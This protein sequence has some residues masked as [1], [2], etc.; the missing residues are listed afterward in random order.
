ME[1]PPRDPRQPLLTG[2]LILRILLVSALLVGGAW[3]LFEWER[4]NGATLAE[5]RTAAL[6]LFVTVEAFYLFSCRSLTHSMWHVGVF[7]N[8][9]ILAGVT[10]Q[11]IGQLAITY[12]PA[13][14]TVFQTAPIAPQAWL[15]ILTI[16]A[17]ATILVALDKRLRR[18]LA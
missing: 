4:S 8:R 7:S 10:A 17:A 5:A 15:R 14:N 9:W 12:V 18:Q 1:R 3:W 16:A 6:N 2:T 11:T 13:M